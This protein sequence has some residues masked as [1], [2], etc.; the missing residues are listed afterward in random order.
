MK[1]A[2]ALAALLA[3]PA[4][5]GNQPA[6]TPAAPQPAAPAAASAAAPTPAGWPSYKATGFSISYPPGFIVDRHHEYEGIGNGNAILGT[7]FFIPPA[8][9]TGTNLSSDSYLSVE[10]FPQVTC[11]PHAFLASYQDL[12]PVNESGRKW[13]VASD[14]EGAAG[15][16]YR[17]TVYALAGSV[18]CIGVRYFIH[19]TEVGN[20]DP[21]TVQPFDIN[22]VT[23]IFDRM[24]QSLKPAMPPSNPG[25]AAAGSR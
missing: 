15:N 6:A 12:P 18:P 3:A 24:R 13:L 11:T 5:A 14:N 17:E 25:Q 10:M 4:F 20:Y 19:S 8:L 9:Y 16:L 1:S 22:R 21:G 2:F 23:A 7:A